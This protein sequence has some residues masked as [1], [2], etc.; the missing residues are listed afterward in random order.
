MFERT[1]LKQYQQL[2]DTI[3]NIIQENHTYTFVY[4]CFTQTEKRRFEELL[5]IKLF[6]KE[7]QVDIKIS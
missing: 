4:N 1:K 6:Y 7:H 3:N 2:Q 5:L